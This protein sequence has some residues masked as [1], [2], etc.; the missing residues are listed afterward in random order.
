MIYYG[1]NELCGKL[2]S[3]LIYAVL[4]KKI[5]QESVAEK[6]FINLYENQAN[7]NDVCEIVH[8]T[9]MDSYYKSISI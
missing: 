3:E 8:C 1:E 7:W 4:V 2:N 6:R 9:A 5:H